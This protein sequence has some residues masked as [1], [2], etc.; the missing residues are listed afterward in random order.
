[1]T[2]RTEDDLR[3]ALIAD[4]DAGAPPID[5][6]SRL[7]RRRARQQRM[8]AGLALT[9]AAAVVATVLLALP[10]HDDATVLPPA[11]SDVRTLVPDRPLSDA[12]LRQAVDTFR[13]RL[14]SLGVQ[15]ATVSTQDDAVLIE[16]S[17][18]TQSDITAI[19]VRGEL[20]FRSVKTIGPATD[21]SRGGDV[22]CSAD[23]NIQYTLG[24]VALDNSDVQHADAVPN[25][26]DNSW[27]VQLD[28]TPVGADKFHTLTADAAAEL[29]Q[30][31]CTPPQACGEIAIVVDGTVLEAPSVQQPGGIEGGQTQITGAVTKEDA[32]TLVALATS[33]PLPTRFSLSD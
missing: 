5:V 8:R 1:M 23:G 7:Q 9:G 10:G 22:A 16:A 19:A 29:D 21:C 25:S 4:A 20:Q 14:D 32:Q 31:V 28:F 27:L 24:P 26:I 11:A 15:H 17:G 18:T 12:E 33:D 30:G 3:A 13:H 2:N 6:W